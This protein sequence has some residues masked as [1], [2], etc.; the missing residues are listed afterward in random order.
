MVLP[1]GGAVLLLA[2]KGSVD[3]CTRLLRGKPPL[4][5]RL[6]KQAV[7]NVPYCAVSKCDEVGP[8]RWILSDPGFPCFSHKGNPEYSWKI[9]L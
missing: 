9:W 4:A 3:V 7:N 6:F 1:A 5:R 2:H 8:D